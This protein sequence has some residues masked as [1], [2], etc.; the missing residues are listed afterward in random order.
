MS[1]SPPHILLFSEAD[2]SQRSTGRWHFLLES[3]QGETLVEASDDEPGVHGERLELL[4]VV[5]GLEALDQPSRVT[6]VTS[7]RQVS[8]GLRSGLDEWRGNHWQWERDGRRVP[9]KNH[10]LWQRIDWAMKFHEVQCR[11]WRLDP[12]PRAMQP[13]PRR[14]PTSRWSHRWGRVGRRAAEFVRRWWGTPAPW[15]ILGAAG[16]SAP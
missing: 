7:S 10:D 11:S 4:A 8:R 3:M 16:P 14:V 1:A 5:R 2:S 9:I 13:T 15:Q 6:L 12:G